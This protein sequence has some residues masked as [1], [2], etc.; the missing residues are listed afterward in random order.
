MPHATSHAEP[1]NVIVTKE[2]GVTLGVELAEDESGCLRPTRVLFAH[3]RPTSQVY[4]MV[5]AGDVLVAVNGV[6]CD[7]GAA[8]AFALRDAGG[9]VTLRVFRPLPEPPWYS[10]AASWAQRAVMAVRASTAEAQRVHVRYKESWHP[11]LLLVALLAAF[12][13]GMALTRGGSHAAPQQHD[14]ERERTQTRL[15]FE[16][17]RTRLRIALVN[18]QHEVREVSNRGEMRQ[19]RLRAES[20]RERER[21]ATTL[22][23]ANASAQNESA[24]LRAQAAIL[25][26]HAEQLQSELRR[27]RA[28]VRKAAREEERRKALSATMVRQHEEAMQGHV[29][30]AERARMRHRQTL[31]DI[32]LRLHAF[33]AGIHAL[34]EAT[35]AASTGDDKLALAPPPEAEPELFSVHVKGADGY[36]KANGCY[37]LQPPLQPPQSPP[38]PQ[39]QH[40]SRVT[41]SSSNGRPSYFNAPAG[42]ELRFYP[43]DLA[44]HSAWAGAGV[45][46]PSD[47]GWALLCDGGLH[48]FVTYGCMAERPASCRWFVR[49]RQGTPPVPSFTLMHGA[50][51]ER[52]VAVTAPLAPSHGPKGHGPQRRP[53]RWMDWDTACAATRPMPSSS[54]AAAAR[55]IE[56]VATALVSPPRR[57]RR[58]EQLHAIQRAL[59]AA[60]DQLREDLHARGV[61]CN[62]SS[63]CTVEASMASLTPMEPPKRRRLPPPPPRPSPLDAQLRV[64]VPASAHSFESRVC[65]PWGASPWMQTGGGMNVSLRATSFWDPPWR[66]KVR[67]G[68]GT[69]A[70]ERLANG[71]L[72]NATHACVEVNVSQLALWWHQHRSR[73]PFLTPTSSSLSSHLLTKNNVS[74]REPN[75]TELAL[76]MQLLKGADATRGVP[77]Q[78]SLRRCA[79]VGSGHDLRCNDRHGRRKGREIDTGFDA[80]FRSNAAQQ[81]D[82]PHKHYINASYAGRRTDFRTNCLFRSQMLPSAKDE[83]LCMLPKGWWHWPWGREETKNTRHACCEKPRSSLYSLETLAR[84]ANESEAQRAVGGRRAR[85]VFID[86]LD[87]AS[88]AVAGPAV[89]NAMHS[90]GGNTLLAATALCDRIDV[91]GMGLFSLPARLGAD[92]VYLHYYDDYVAAC[93]RSYDAGSFTAGSWALKWLKQRLADELTLHL[94]HALGVVHWRTD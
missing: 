39:L 54:V 41:N 35:G 62:S 7:S 36:P 16:R 90:T 73:P 75:A 1:R 46:P 91:F 72:T 65:D 23:L 61:L 43:F 78:Q 86:A 76:L 50:N 21:L 52:R 30:R 42:C 85:L 82:H 28:A 83:S 4:G 25:T 47:V 71:L 6:P 80:V 70:R 60:V 2:A 45:R 79:F 87:G 10:G 51:C 32:R 88:S 58:R 27:A 11:A 68:G 19:E 67:G 12:V 14:I 63:P 17:E 34:E 56:Q 94:L 77:Q 84:L 59:S 5:E 89:A 93:E 29:Q 69:S 38:P 55:P 15:D 24:A 37:R 74:Q 48:R 3:V 22:K 18:K 26:Q 57:F 20:R 49:K 64:C 81:L 9:S 40:P 13:V 53:S 92:K 66:F 31:R 33:V 44:A 8:A